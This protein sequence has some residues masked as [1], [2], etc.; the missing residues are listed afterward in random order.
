MSND[1]V[2]T[3]ILIIS[4]LMGL[5]A[6]F[7]P[8]GL[9]FVYVFFQT[10]KRKRIRQRVLT[11]Q[12]QFIGN[13]PWIPV[14]FAS[15]P[16][17]NSWFKIFPWEGAGILLLAPG[18]VTFLGE[19]NAG[20]PVNL[21]FAPGNSTLNWIGKSPFPN[22]A[23]SWFDFTTASGRHYFSSETGAFVFGSHRSTKEAFDQASRSFA[24]IQ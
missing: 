22:G 16:R 24:G 2:Q 17:F 9:F 6:L 20:R 3:I 18:S 14:R 19:T 8:L 23:V 13:H 5:A 12:A 4:L 15:E 7:V 10:S 21:Q 1:D 11:E